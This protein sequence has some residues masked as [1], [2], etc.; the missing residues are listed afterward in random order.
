VGAIALTA[1]L[2]T[3]VYTGH[4]TLPFLAPTEAA[5][6][7]DVKNHL[8]AAADHGHLKRP[9]SV[10]CHR[11]HAIDHAKKLMDFSGSYTCNITWVDG[12]KQDACYIARG[13]R[14]VAGS[15]PS[16]CEAAAEGG[17]GRPPN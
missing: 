7:R 10:T 9:R 1:V 6:T 15:L 11:S 17:W 8:E 13:S 16:S 12:S 4:V 2:G 3:L 14:T 5:A